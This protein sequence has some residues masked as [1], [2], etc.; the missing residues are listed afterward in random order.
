MDN[1]WLGFIIAFC[2]AAAIL[3]PLGIKFYKHLK[4]AVDNGDWSAIMSLTIKLMGEAKDK[5]EKGADKKEWVLGQ[6]RIVSQEL[7]Y[8]LDEEVIGRFIDSICD[9]GKRLYQ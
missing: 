5:F 6:L 8:D 1:F 7:N 3:I 9:L 2:A 4:N